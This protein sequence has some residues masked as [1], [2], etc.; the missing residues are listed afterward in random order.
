[1]GHEYWFKPKTYG[2]GATP[3]TWEGWA[4]V[5]VYTLVLAACVVAMTLRKESLA[6]YV[7]SL[8]MIVV[9]TTAMI[10]VSVRKTDGGWHWSWGDTENSGKNQ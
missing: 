10:V 4:V 7:S 3:T 9:A 5:A 6:T 8:G 1:M 2:Y